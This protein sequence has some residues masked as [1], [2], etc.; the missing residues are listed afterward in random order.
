MTFQTPILDSKPAHLA[1]PALLVLLTFLSGCS[2]LQGDK[3]DYKSASTAKAPTLQHNFRAKI[4]DFR[5]FNF[6]FGHFR[7]VFAKLH[8]LLL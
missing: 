4:Y 8:V 1:L 5:L 2:A 6:L 3:I 7:I